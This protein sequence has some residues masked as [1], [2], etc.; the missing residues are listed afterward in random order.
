MLIYPAVT[1][2]K[3]GSHPFRQFIL[4][5]AFNSSAVIKRLVMIA[6]WM[7]LTIINAPAIADASEISTPAIQ[8]APVVIDGDVLFIL[9]GV[10]SF[11]ADVRAAAIE[12]RIKALAT[13][14][15]FDPESIRI[16][17]VSE[18]RINIQAG[19]QVIFAV[20]DA[21]AAL[22]SLP[23][24]LLAETYRL[25]LIIAINAYRHDRETSVLMLHAGY[26]LL[27]TLVLAGLIYGMRWLFRQFDRMLEKQLQR[28]IKKLE[29]KSRN[30]VR[31]EQVWHV[32]RTLV[33]WA[34][35]LL[36]AV[37]LYVYLNSVLGLFPWTRAIA[38]QLFGLILDPLKTIGI[39]IIDFLPSL[40]FLVILT[41]F[42]RYI[43]K[44]TRMFFSAVEY[45][46]MQFEGFDAEWADP[47]YRIVRIVIIALSLVVAYPYIPGSSS[48]AF[49][50]VSLFFGVLLSLGSSSVISNIIAGY[51][52]TYRRAFKDGDRIKIGD[53]V[54]TVTARRV[55][56][57]HLR[58]TKNEEVVIPN[59]LVLNSEIVNYSTLAKRDGLILHT[60]V[61]IGYEVPWRQVEA[62]LLL[63]AERTAGL[64]ADKQPFVQQ[65][66]LGDY[67]V[68]YEL[69]VYCDQV[70]RIVDLYSQLHR[71][72]QDVFNEYG[73]Q[74]MT[75]SYESDTPD[76]KIVP[77]EKWFSAPAKAPTA[78]EI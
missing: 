13:D 65:T 1:S 23:S 18:D 68:N 32:L 42:V 63:A 27:A 76:A 56:V 35:V 33:G 6:V 21:D 34:R 37:I 46:R 75:P 45:G 4:K 26:A 70:D 44:V 49:K 60:T 8:T 41:F 12:D 71:N 50:G 39:A 73:V 66:L 77:R 57:T 19:E 78:D 51:T 52:M 11:P 17:P 53:T 67:A 29:S 20:F 9:R 2:N 47:T 74:I 16:V 14:T 36:I 7:L 55:L 64:R 15:N 62:M 38:Q 28:H 5:R 69:N 30:I 72:I 58:T 25:R 3:P 40:L 48:E 54:G 59:S 10:T 61:G 22:E 24:K 43:L 31:S